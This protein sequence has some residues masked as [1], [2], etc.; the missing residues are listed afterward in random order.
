MIE[1][2]LLL[3][4]FVENAEKE[5]KT[6][7]LA[8]F[9]ER[10]SE[11]IFDA[12]KI[13]RDVAKEIHIGKTTIYEYLS[14]TKMPSLANLIKLADYF[15]CPTDYLLGLE[16]EPY[17]RTFKACK[18]F[19]EQFKDILAYFD[20]TRYKLER[21]TGI[22]QSALYYWAKGEKTPTVEKILIICEKLD[23]RVDF[24][25]GRSNLR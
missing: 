13:A 20:I 21:L 14:G 10:L 7:N 24:F 22:A 19:P 2:S 11:L 9:A 23:C 16:A 12:K 8:I 25:I 17:E 3:S 18:P 1:W 15:E 6:L 5:Q 4:Y